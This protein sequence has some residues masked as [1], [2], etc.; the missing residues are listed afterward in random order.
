MN[1]KNKVIRIAKDFSETP[2][3]RSRARGPHSGQKF[4]EDMLEPL[5]KKI[6][7]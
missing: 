2:G 6:L 7:S 4:R 1:E 5:F 3:G